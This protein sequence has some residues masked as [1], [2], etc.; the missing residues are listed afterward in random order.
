MV[1][2]ET[3][4]NSCS[5]TGRGLLQQLP[6]VVGMLGS[7][8]VL[9]NVHAW[10]PLLGLVVERRADERYEQR[11][12]PGGPALQLGVGLSSDDEGMHVGRV[13]DELDQ[14]PVRGCAGELSPACGGAVRRFVVLLV[15]GTVSLGPRG[16]LICLRHN[17]T[18]LQRGRV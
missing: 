8:R 5:A 18:R 4:S 16:S 12:R 15:A 10:Q 7:V 13:L 2:E 14:V 9:S 1:S 3:V 6:D 17:G 11:V